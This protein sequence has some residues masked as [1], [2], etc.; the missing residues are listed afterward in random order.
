MDISTTITRD[1]VFRSN[2][3]I[4][5]LCKRAN[6]VLVSTSDTWNIC[7]YMSFNSVQRCR[8]KSTTPITIL[9]IEILSFHRELESTFFLFIGVIILA[10]LFFSFYLVPRVIC[11]L[12]RKNIS[13]NISQMAPSTLNDPITGLCLALGR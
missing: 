1:N 8:P 6:E 3:L 11:E 12:V 5:D 9:L 13:E 7:F 4:I 10:I 2:A